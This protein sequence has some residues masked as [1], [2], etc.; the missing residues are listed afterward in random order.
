MSCGNCDHCRVEDER[1]ARNTWAFA[2]GILDYVCL[3]MGVRRSEVLSKS[4]TSRLIMPRRIV[5]YLIRELT[6]L[7]TLAIGTA[8]NRD[9]STVIVGSQVIAARMLAA[10]AFAMR[11]EAM[12]AKLRGERK[13]AA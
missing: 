6:D 1:N 5:Y 9:H 2:S 10:P 12:S 3:E 11:I 4:R 8:L 13:A 7:S